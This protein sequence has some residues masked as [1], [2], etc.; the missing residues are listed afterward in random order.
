[1]QRNPMSLPF[2]GAQDSFPK[3]AKLLQCNPFISKSPLRNVC[4]QQFLD[5]TFFKKRGCCHSNVLIMVAVLP[6]FPGTMAIEHNCLG[7]L[8][9]TQ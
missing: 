9:G 2:L 7:Y 5:I 6:V 4:S 8:K 3:E 1:M